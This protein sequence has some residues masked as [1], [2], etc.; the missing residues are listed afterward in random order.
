MV[1]VANYCQDY[2]SSGHACDCA[3]SGRAAGESRACCS[4]QV[5]HEGPADAGRHPESLDEARQLESDDHQQLRLAKRRKTNREC[6]A[7]FR[8]RQVEE[9]IC[10][11]QAVTARTA[12]IAHAR[13]KRL[14]LLQQRLTL[15]QRCVNASEDLL[16]LLRYD[17]TN[18]RVRAHPTAAAPGHAAQHGMGRRAADVAVA[19]PAVEDTQPNPESLTVRAALSK[20]D[21]FVATDAWGYMPKYWESGSVYR[22]HT[23]GKGMGDSG[24][25]GEVGGGAQLAQRLTARLH[26]CRLRVARSAGVQP[27]AVRWVL[28]SPHAAEDGQALSFTSALVS[29]QCMASFYACHFGGL[30]EE[31]M[32]AEAP[33]HVGE[34]MENERAAPACSQGRQGGGPTASAMH[35]SHASAAVTVKALDTAL[36]GVEGAPACLLLMTCGLDSCAPVATAVPSFIRR[37]CHAYRLLLP[38]SQWMR[39]CSA[40]MRFM[41]AQTQHTSLQHA[42]CQHWAIHAGSGQAHDVATCPRCCVLAHIFATL[43]EEVLANPTVHQGDTGSAEAVSLASMSA[44]AHEVFGFRGLF[45]TQCMVDKPVEFRLMCVMQVANSATLHQERRVMLSMFQQMQLSK[46][47]KQAAAAM[48]RLW[49]S[50]RSK[51]DDR[52]AGACAS[53]I[54][55]LGRQD[56][57]LAGAEHAR[58]HSVRSANHVLRS[59]AGTLSETHSAAV[60]DGGC[61]CICQ[62]CAARL[63]Q[64]LH[65]VIGHST[66]SVQHGVSRLTHTHDREAAKHVEL[67]RML[68]MPYVLFT[69][70][71]HAQQ[72]ALSLQH[73]V[74]AD[75]LW[76][77]KNA[78]EDLEQQDLVH[79]VNDCLNDM[80]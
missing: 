66:S 49:H 11:A 32:L 53:L 23:C 56:I 69:P 73:G 61:V 68:Y 13:S 65:G 21:A 26:D 36:S 79:S 48:W 6:Q 40:Y 41:A 14:M 59:P 34:S 29:P 60:V 77:C 46:E 12:S 43:R 20:A 45:M 52:F 51:L 50:T 63:T 72:A 71:Q 47:Q 67:L 76:L 39:A 30:L 80:H 2:S 8:R 5:H 31:A 38:R 27:H 19:V 17:R 15:D 18:S 4:A 78:A 9:R 37:I 25:S 54:G 42:A 62:A 44:R 35:D 55:L 74:T 22:L 3:T 75:W 1:N 57:K 10:M 28:Q 7:R 16:L 58:E 24:G 64:R 70:G 33:L